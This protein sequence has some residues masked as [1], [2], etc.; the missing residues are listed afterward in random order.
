M[1]VVPAGRRAEAAR[2]Q[3]ESIR[4]GAALMLLGDATAEDTAERAVAAARQE[5][6]RSEVWLVELALKSLPDLAEALEELDGLDLASLRAGSILT[7]L[8]RFKEVSAEAA[9]GTLQDALPEEEDR[10][11]RTRGPK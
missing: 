2:R 11:R 3:L 4:P 1:P 7:T 10:H 6:T 5:L 9:L 8:L